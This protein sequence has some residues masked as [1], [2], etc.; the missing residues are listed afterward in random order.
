MSRQTIESETMGTGPGGFRA[1]RRQNG[2][3]G[4]Y[5]QR[6]IVRPQSQVNG[7]NERKGLAAPKFS[8]GGTAS[9]PR[10]DGPKCAPWIRLWFGVAVWLRC[11][12]DG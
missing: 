4:A 9:V 2:K 10:G 1:G 5:R 12:G 3:S 6:R 11:V 7:F 8:H